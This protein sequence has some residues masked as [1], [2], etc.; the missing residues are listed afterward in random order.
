[1]AEAYAIVREHLGRNAEVMKNSYD[2]A[3]KPAQ[4]Q[5]DDQVWY[6]CPRSRPGTSPKWTRFYTGPYRVVRKVNDV[7]Y[8]IRSTARSRQMVVHVKT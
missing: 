2:A 8:V 6:F 7:N 5:V 3:V 1:M 4:F